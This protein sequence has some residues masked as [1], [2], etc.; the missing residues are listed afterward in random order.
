MLILDSTFTS[1]VSPTLRHQCLC[2]LGCVTRLVITMPG[3]NDMIPQQNTEYIYKFAMQQ[4]DSILTRECPCRLTLPKDPHPPSHHVKA[5]K[6]EPISI[7][8]K[9]VLACSKLFTSV[10]YTS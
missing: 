3:I 6:S 8:S 4:V 7:L 2:R 10:I 1:G 5:Q 9:R